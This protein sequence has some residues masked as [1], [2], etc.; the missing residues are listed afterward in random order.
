MNIKK[1][2]ALYFSPTGGT[3][4]IAEHIASGLC[5]AAEFLDVTSSGRE[6]A[7]GPEDFVVIAVPVF[8]GRVP[9]PTAERLSHVRA[10]GTP[11]AIVAVYGNRAYEDALLELRGLAEERGFKVMAAAAFIARHSIHGAFRQDGSYEVTFNNYFSGVIQRDS[12]VPVR[13]RG[14]THIFPALSHSPQLA[15]VVTIPQNWTLGE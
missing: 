9:S 5:D 14:R 1:S 2:S 4:K 6:L 10:E 3:K 8:G 11:A 13:E 12:N 7:F 15:A